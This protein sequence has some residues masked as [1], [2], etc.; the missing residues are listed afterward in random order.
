MET[1]EPKKKK[2]PEISG[3]SEELANR[4]CDVVATSTLPLYELKDI[5]PSLPC[6]RTIYEWK[7]KYPE[8]AIK[9]NNAKI[10]QAENTAQQIYEIAETV[11][12]YF[13]KD[14]IE[15]IDPGQL[16]KMRLKMD[17]LKWIACKLVPRV[18]GERQAISVQPSTET[19]HLEFLKQALSKT[20]KHD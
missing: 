14:G 15:R 8:F 9:F 16:G 5:D 3:Y 1:K 13:D 2:R 6:K 18:Y 7:W 4:V 12:T 11:P 10:Q 19:A 20:D 17:T